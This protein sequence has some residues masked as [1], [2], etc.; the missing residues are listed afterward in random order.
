MLTFGQWWSHGCVSG[1]WSVDTVWQT[2]WH[3]GLLG[4]LG[5][6]AAG[7]EVIHCITVTGMSQIKQSPVSSSWN[8][9]HGGSW[10]LNGTLKIY[11]LY[12][13]WLSPQKKKN[14]QINTYRKLMVFMLK[15]LGWNKLMTAICL[16]YIKNKGLTNRYVQSKYS[17]C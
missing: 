3:L 16:K 13:V 15:C 14:P 11:T 4:E 2:G 5:H 12:C 1:Y 9:W 7:W 17:R 6:C 10:I 8:G